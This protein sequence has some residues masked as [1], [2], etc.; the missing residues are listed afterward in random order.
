MLV[1]ASLISALLLSFVAEAAAA[2]S[3][4]NAANDAL[5]GT[6]PPEAGVKRATTA[7]DLFGAS[8]P[9]A[10]PAANAAAAESLPTAGPKMIRSGKQRVDESG[11]RYFASQNQA[12][13]VEKEIERLKAL[14]PDWSPP[15]DLS[16]GVPG[17]PE[18]QP[19]WDLFAQDKL[20]EMRN[21]IAEKMKAEPNWKPSAGLVYK[22]ERKESRIKLVAAYDA[23]QWNKVIEVAAADPKIVV[24]SDVDVP[25]RVADAFYNLNRKSQAFEVY[26]FILSN[27]RDKIER[28]TTLRKAMAYFEPR[29]IDVLI[30]MGARNKDGSQEFDEIR[31]ELSRIRLGKFAAGGT[32]EKLSAPELKFFETMAKDKTLSADASMLGWYRLSQNEARVAADW[33]RQALD[34]PVQKREDG[35]VMEPQAKMAEGY[36]LA[37]KSLERFEEAEAVAVKWSNENETIRALFVDILSEALVRAPADVAFSPDRLSRYEMIVA[38]GKSVLGAQALGWYRFARQNYSDAVPWFQAS[39]DWSEADKKDIKTAE[40]LAISLRQDS[41]ADEAEDIAYEWRDKSSAMR[42]L[43][44]D[45]FAES[46]IRQ[47]APIVFSEARLLRY[48]EIIEPEKSGQGAEGLAWYAFNRQLWGDAARWFKN[49]I[50][51]TESGKTNEKF[52]E[53]YAQSLR[54]IGNYDAAEDIAYEW[55]ETSRVLRALYID[56][57]VEALGKLPTSEAHDLKRFRRFTEL[58]AADRSATGAEAIGWYLYSRQSFTDAVRWFQQA[59]DYGVAKDRLEKVAEGYILALRYMGDVEKAED[60]A[61]RDSSKSEALRTVYVEIAAEALTRLKPPTAA[62]PDKLERFTTL[63]S[64][65]RSSFGA[66]A[67]GW[68]YQQRDNSAAAADW[69]NRS[70]AWGGKITD[71]KTA[72]GY[73]LALISQDRMDEA[74]KLAF[75][76]HERSEEFRT[77]YIDVFGGAIL[78]A[79]P[80]QVFPEQMLTRFAYITAYARSVF[81]SQAVA[82]YYYDR[83]D[84]PNASRWFQASLDWSG[85]GNHDQK[86]VEGFAQSI[87]YLARR[88]EAEDILYAWRDKVPLLRQ[89]YLELF[90]EALANTNPPVF[91]SDERINR[92]G[93]LIL[94]DK[95]AHAAQG[96]GWYRLD[97]RHWPDAVRW[98]KYAREWSKDG[99]GS[100][101]DAEGLAFALRNLDLYDES[102]FVSVE[103]KDRSPVLRKLYSETVGEYLVRLKPEHTYPNERMERYL[104][105][106]AEDHNNVGAQSAGWYYFA[107]DMFEPAAEWF[108]ASLAWGPDQDRDPKTAEGYV[109]SLRRTGRLLDAEAAAY[110]LRDRSPAMREVYFQIATEVIGQLKPPIAFPAERLAY[111]ME[112]AVAA[113]SAPAAQAIAWYL[114]AREDWQEAVAWFERSLDWGGDTADP[115]AAEGYLVSLIGLGR[116]D[117]ADAL[118]RHWQHHNPGIVKIYMD[119]FGATLLRLANTQEVPAG[120]LEQFGAYAGLEKNVNAAEALAWYAYN[121]R[122]WDDAARWF[123]AS[124][125]WAGSGQ[126]DAKSIEGFAQA[127][128]YLGRRDEAEDLLFQWRDANADLHRL[129][130]ESFA[131]ALVNQSAPVAFD[132]A[133]INRYAQV[134]LSDRSSLGAQSLAW[135]RYNRR[136]W[137]DAVRWFKHA[138]TWS[139]DGKGDAKMAEGLAF[140]LRNMDLYDESE[141]VSWEWRDRAPAVRTLY[142]ET[143]AEFIVRLKPRETYPVDRMS[144]YQQVLTTDRSSIG[145]QAAGWYYFAR[146]RWSDAIPWFR[147]ALA[148]GPDHNRDPKTAEGLAIALMNSGQADEAESFAYS[149]RD[150]SERLAAMYYEFAA[151]AM[152]RLDPSRA[153]PADRMAR[154][155]AMT[156]GSRNIFASQ[157]L[158]WYYIARRQWNEAAE[159]FKTS[160][161]WSGDEKDL[162]TIEGYTIAL[163]SLDR[164]DEAEAFAYSWRDKSETLAA[165]YLDTVIDT[166]SRLKADSVY[167]PERLAAFVK[168]VGERKYVAGARAL[169]WYRLERKEDSEAETWFRH[170]NAWAGEDKDLKSFEGLAIA[171]RRQNKLD[172]AA[173]LALEWRGKSE[174]MRDM[175]RDSIADLMIRTKAPATLPADRM[176]DFV[177]LAKA[178]RNAGA[179]LSLGWYFYDRKDW[180]NAT[181][182]FRSAMEWET[183]QKSTKGAE[184]YVLT[185]RN[186]GKIEEAETAAYEWRDRSE[187][188]RAL[189][190]DMVPEL[191]SK[192]K[193]DATFP[194]DRLNRF[195]A[196]VTAAKSAYGA[197]ALAWY[198]YERKDQ[199]Q[200]ATWFKSALDWAGDAKDPKMAEGYVLALRATGQHDLAETI[201]YEWRD[202]AD[203]LRAQYIETFAESLT[204]TNPPPPFPADRL[205]RYTALVSA[206]KNAIGAQALGWYSYNIKQYR[207]A[208]AWFEKA[209]QWAPSEGSALGL[210]LSARAM[211]DVALYNTVLATYRG[212]YPKLVDLLTPQAGATPA[213]QQV[214]AS[215]Q[216]PRQVIETVEVVTTAGRK[217]VTRPA[218]NAA[219]IPT[220]SGGKTNNAACIA[221]VEARER[222]GTASAA[223]MVNKGWCLLNAERPEEAA[224]AFGRGQGARGQSGEDAAYGR[225]LALLRTGVTDE[226]AMA[227]SGAPISEKR[228]QDIGTQVM[229]QKIIAAQRAG[230]Y[231][232]ALRLLDQRSAYVPETRDLSMIRGW[233][234]YNLGR[235]DASRRVFTELDRQLSTNETQNALAV[236]NQIRGN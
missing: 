137:G 8:T 138:R 133:R 234:L 114:N 225:A 190:I 27:C 221:N 206:D 229:A 73:L 148:W 132:D 58:V 67:I 136:I 178:G 109:E 224:V 111:F 202:R 162:K 92:Y 232:D 72:Q 186:T 91:F 185:L 62:R 50:D 151:D 152:G 235:K 54:G 97:R 56:T 78:R 128:R 203:A 34:W 10:A 166:L 12:K 177:D 22:L 226:A 37:L 167:S 104:R 49:A 160:L 159:W 170:A 52:A 184:G 86:T 45:I 199:A 82:W 215:T 127:L 63:V 90:S 214:F 153:Y 192:L 93:N 26:R 5:S 163:R 94:P 179:A 18:E 74:D 142:I 146:D 210:A 191:L 118:I 1:R 48:G 106:V 102:E 53:G 236:V 115:K 145:A 96:L 21:L 101:K 169:G 65:T 194:N 83:Q 16:L 223:D 108:Y 98:F 116:L 197:Q 195:A 183:D 44:I 17:G 193:P 64:Q 201:A 147:N 112:M 84:W 3:A 107:R 81:G 204:R 144:R 89:L 141:A 165:I 76:W 75:E 230:Q 36:L 140:A 31:L 126:Y 2:E 181:A 51:W 168:L 158:G 88:E 47:N 80:P 13:R 218:A 105:V 188:M 200:A 149:W 41:R 213:T 85:T 119:V 66:Q 207:P 113:R 154:L 120:R 219:P 29:E 180:A 32:G 175:Y 171:L 20:A 228:R 38:Q 35:T 212:T 222:A 61:F 19:F 125:T 59:M 15:D 30:A 123:Q 130:V 79:T 6:K 110:E 227:A 99:K 231:L 39:L 139:P 77:L 135:Y 211:R 33:F 208:R 71:A 57:V 87:R 155:V 68:Y 24:C 70:L 55:R 187:A 60:L 40:G 156:R 220:T 9:G 198:R 196:Q 122:N 173:A 23:Q 129:Y 69:F 157:S 161:D 103:W 172:D 182:W 209:L 216:Q 28:L 174:I 131:E 43:Y 42:A 164:I 25:W 233:A 11:L 176:K 46:L 117:E 95:N 121:R 100:A 189:Y 124:L 150:R 134:V 217:T 14:Y 205:T 143:V 7:E 4:Q